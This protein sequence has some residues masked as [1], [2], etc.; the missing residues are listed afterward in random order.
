MEVLNEDGTILTV[1]RGVLER[2]RTDFENL[3]N[4]ISNDDF[5]YDHFN[6]V[7]SEK[8]TR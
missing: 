3:Y 1:E 8:N 5:D 6:F 4:G 7:K 2:L